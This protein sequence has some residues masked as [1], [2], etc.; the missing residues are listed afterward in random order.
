MQ[1]K[2]HPK[3]LTRSGRTALLAAMLVGG[4][5]VAGCAGSSS[6]S[7][8]GTVGSARTP[9]LSTPSTRPKTV[10]SSATAGSFG[11]GDLAF[12][13]CMRANGVS[14]FPDPSSAPGELYNTSGIDTAAPAFLAASAK[15]HGLT[16]SGPPIPGSRTHPSAQTLAMLRRIAICMRAHGVPQFP[17]PRTTIPSNLASVPGGAGVIANFD[18]AIL[19]FPSSMQLTMQSPAYKQALTACGAPPLGLPHSH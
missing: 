11:S 10:R 13:R 5:V 2:I 1:V 18:G 12:S 3:Q 19:V 14:N 9:P 16:G 15:C 7:T 6:G 4:V 17:D 8:A